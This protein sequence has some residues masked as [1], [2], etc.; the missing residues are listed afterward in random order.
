[1]SEKCSAECVCRALR[2]PRW[3]PCDKPAKVTR[4]GKP[5]CLRHDPERVKA[6]RDARLAIANAKYEKE[7]QRQERKYECLQACEGM[8]NP[9]EEVKATRELL[10]KL[11]SFF[12]EDNGELYWGY[13]EG[14]SVSDVS[15]DKDFEQQLIK[16]KVE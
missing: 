9:V 1:M 7:R 3:Y 10:K 6:K 15:E 14:Q 5:Y 2:F 16:R 4:D 8:A 11:L 13:K 12:Y